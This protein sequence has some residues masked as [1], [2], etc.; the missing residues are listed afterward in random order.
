MRFALALPK[1]MILELPPC[2]WFMKKNIT[3]TSSRIGRSDVRNESHGLVFCGST[4][5]V[6]SGLALMPSA[7]SWLRVSS[8]TNAD[9]YFDSVPA[10]L[11]FSS[12]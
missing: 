10:D 7:M 12:L 8:P 9:V 4:L 5:Y 2:I 6:I 1:D 11:A 3:N